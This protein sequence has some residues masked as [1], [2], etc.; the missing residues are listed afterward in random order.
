MKMKQLI[1]IA[2]VCLLLLVGVSNAYAASTSRYFVKIELPGLQT[3]GSQ[4]ED[5]AILNMGTLQDWTVSW[6]GMAELNANGKATLNGGFGNYIWE[7]SYSTTGED[8]DWTSFSQL[9]PTLTT[10]GGQVADLEQNPPAQTFYAQ[11]F[12]VAYNINL[13][14]T[15]ASVITADGVGTLTAVPEPG[16]ILAAFAILAPVGFVFRRRSL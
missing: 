15:S 6:T 14:N 10:T 8:N 7:Y 13:Q 16:T 12:K 2:V 9:S 11:Y 1:S 3:S 4:N 5:A